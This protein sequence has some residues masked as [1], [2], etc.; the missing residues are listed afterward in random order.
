MPITNKPAIENLRICGKKERLSSSFYSVLRLRNGYLSPK[1]MDSWL[2]FQRFKL[3]NSGL[4]LIL[5]D[6]RLSGIYI[7]FETNL[8]YHSR[9]GSKVSSLPL[10]VLEQRAQTFAFLQSLGTYPAARVPSVCVSTKQL[11]FRWNTLSEY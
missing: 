9:L 5:I 4:A 8:T 7:S 1:C 6:P 11:E 10:S 3:S 2:I